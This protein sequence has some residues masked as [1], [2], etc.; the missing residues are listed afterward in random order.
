MKNWIEIFRTGT[1][2]DSQG[3]TRTWTE[4]DLDKMVAKYDPAGHEAP[5]VIGHPKENAP[6]Y[7]WV[8]KLKR[9]GSK[10]YARFHQVQPAFA[11]MIKSGAFKKR[12]IA[13][14]KDGA[15]RH[16]GFLG[17]QPPAIKGLADIEFADG[18][19]LETYEFE[20]PA[21]PEPKPKEND[22]MPTVEE[23]QKKL[24]DEKAAR[25][26]A[27]ANAKT[28]KTQAEKFQSDFAENRK[29]AARKTIADFIDTGVKD[30][31]ILPAWKNQ[32]LATLMEHLEGVT[33]NTAGEYEFAEGEGK[34]TPAQWFRDFISSFSEHPLFK[35]MAPPENDREEP[36]AG[37]EFSEDLT[38][39]V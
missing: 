36:G 35:E 29:K 18:D 22:D 20:E 12:S 23:L 13:M 34:K 6:A 21:D 11:E 16:V 26:A 37:A 27:E 14:Y 3:R 31:K 38:G 24:A 4:A 15:L 25:E 2:T 39:C 19:D 33:D 32:G 9:A 7:G 5:A 28:Y 10:L 1:H 17:A 30:G 8:E